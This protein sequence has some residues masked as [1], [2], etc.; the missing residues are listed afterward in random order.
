ME[1][2]NFLIRG[3][4]KYK[5]ESM[6]KEL[7]KP[8]FA[9]LKVCTMFVGSDIDSKV[10]VPLLRQY[11]LQAE[12][13]IKEFLKAKRQ[14]KLYDAIRNPSSESEE[15]WSERLKYLSDELKDAYV[16]LRTDNDISNDQL[17]YLKD[18]IVYFRSGSERALKSIEQNVGKILK[19][20]QLNSL[21]IYDV[22]LNQ[23]SAVS[24]LK[25]LV[26]NFSGQDDVKLSVKDVKKLKEKDPEKHK[27]YLALRK[28]LNDIAKKAIA[29]IVRSSGKPLI[30]VD[31][32][33]KKLKEKNIEVHPIP[34]GFKGL[35]DD[36][37][38]F[39][40]E[41]GKFIGS[42]PPGTVEMNPNYDPKLDNAYVFRSNGGGL[43]NSYQ[44]YYTEKHKS[45]ARGQKFEKVQQAASNIDQVRKKWQSNIINWKGDDKSV[46]SLELELAF[47]YGDRIGSGNGMTDGSPTYGLSTIM[48]QH[49]TV[50]PNSI[51]IKYRGKKGKEQKHIIK[52]TG[53]KIDKLVFKY[54][55]ELSANKKKNEP[56]FTNINGKHVGAPIVN[57]YLKSFGSKVTV[58]KARHIKANQ[59]FN[60]ELIK[61][62]K[63]NPTEKDLEKYVKDVADHVGKVLG[64]QTVNSK[65]ETVTNKMTS[66][67]NYVNPDTLR[68]FW[69]KFGLRYPTWLAKLKT[70]ED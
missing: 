61:Y 50:R 28:E 39:Y 34:S 54:L 60:E 15:K 1:V 19:D 56:I 69:D 53:S 21:F 45:V 24:K 49:V 16:Q 42:P 31:V 35:V 33:L 43:F 58:H 66:L 5:N 70:A 20:P 44:R 65:G 32:L 25:R 8:F 68:M 55:M 9:Y 4:R 46:A 63:K 59:L 52:N 6:A 10:N 27:E 57:G 18:L 12:P 36:K 30:N 23:G 37:G 13:F 40:T 26:K 17:N 29:N 47:K 51:T 14:I 22:P 41:A 62:N 48:G 64:H 38:Q 7:V 11:M 2:K 3:Q 67:N